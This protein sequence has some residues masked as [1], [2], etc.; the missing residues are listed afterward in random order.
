[1]EEEGDEEK[2]KS[3]RKKKL[4]DKSRGMEGALIR[5]EV[6]EE[7]KKKKQEE[8]RADENEGGGVEARMTRKNRLRKWRNPE[9]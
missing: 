5:V 2:K 3:G 6:E 7:E 8:W 4:R 9:R 1:M